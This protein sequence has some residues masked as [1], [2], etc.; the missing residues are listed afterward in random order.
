MVKNLSHRQKKGN[1][2]YTLIYRVHYQELHF[3]NK[4]EVCFSFQIIYLR[5]Y[6]QSAQEF[7][8]KTKI[9][10]QF[11]SVL[12]DATSHMTVKSFESNEIMR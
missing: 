6:M 3:G 12:Y 5:R 11:L 9:D 4:A 10:V 7:F 8:F 1:M 2:V